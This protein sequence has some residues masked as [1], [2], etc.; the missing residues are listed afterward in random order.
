MCKAKLKYICKKH[1]NI[2]NRQAT[3]NPLP[4]KKQCKNPFD[5]NVLHTLQIKIKISYK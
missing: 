5:L 1:Q 3:Q 4:L 2:G